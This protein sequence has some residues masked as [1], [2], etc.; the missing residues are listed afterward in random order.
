MGLEREF[1]LEVLEPIRSRG[2][3]D[4]T[5]KMLRAVGVHVQEQV[6]P[7]GLRLIVPARSVI[8]PAA[9]LVCEGDWSTAAAL[10]AVGAALPLG[11]PI[12]ELKGLSPTS[13]Q[14]DRVF[15]DWLGA[16]GARVEWM[17]SSLTVFP[18]R[19]SLRG[20]RVS[21][22]RSPDLVPVF[23]ALAAI[24]E[25]RSEVHSAPQLRHK[26]SDRIALGVRLANLLGAQAHETVDGF[27]VDSSAG[28]ELPRSGGWSTDHDHRQVMAAYV[29]FAGGARFTIDDVSVVTKSAP[30]F[31]EVMRCLG[32]SSQAARFLFLGHRGAG[33]TSFARRL[34]ESSAGRLEVCD[35]DQEIERRYERSI[36]DIFASDGE[37][38]FRE[39]ERQELEFWLRQPVSEHGRVI[40]AGAGIELDQLEPEPGMRGFRFW[41]RAGYEAVWVSR[42]T[43]LQ[44]RVFLDRPRLHPELSAI[45]EYRLRAQAR[46][47]RYQRWSSRQIILR[48]GADRGNRAS[49]AERTVIFGLPDFSGASITIPQ[50]VLSDF[51]RL[52]AWVSLRRHWSFSFF[53]VRE[54]Y[55]PSELSAPV[56]EALFQ[57]LSTLGAK[58]LIFS[59]RVPRPGAGQLVLGA[60]VR[61]AGGRIDWAQELGDSNTISDAHEGDIQSIH[62]ELPPQRGP[63]EGI[64]KWSPEI[65]DWKGL[66]EGHQWWAQDPKHRVFLPRSPQGIWRHYRLWSAR[67]LRPALFF[68]REGVGSALDQPT[69]V[70]WLEN[71]GAPQEFGAVLGDPVLH[72]RSPERHGPHF[73]GFP[74]SREEFGDALEFLRDQGLN[75]A[76]VT[77]PLKEDCFQWVR[78]LGHTSKQPVMIS[79]RANRLAS[80]NTLFWCADESGRSVLQADNTDLPG[81]ES[82][83]ASLG[84]GDG[85]QVALW[86]GGGTLAMVRALLPS[87]RAYSARTG[88]VKPGGEASARSHE[89]PRVVIW[90]VGRSIFSGLFPP[91]SWRPELVIDLNYAEDSP[92]RDY[93]A[94]LLGSARYL[95]GLAFFEAQAARQFRSVKPMTH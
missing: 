16:M 53:E 71:R 68:L 24:A 91:Q 82:V 25:G 31:L 59:R 51:K 80:V 37:A 65:Q 60:H 15:I 8:S 45:E 39:L 95:S 84:L 13:L 43:D 49:L 6:I 22:E 10:M 62:G 40:V 36:S 54:D 93:A 90:G 33:K 64:L 38:R 67:R 61:E 73:F 63:H 1:S 89:S 17:G 41:E 11:A 77:S 50:S 29:A 34:R 35:L 52:A 94:R 92:G 81:F 18:S 46:D 58:R 42:E 21:G 86:G 9:V 85:S 47:Q 26:E 55:L 27:V 20:I 76:A 3:L 12:L 78:Q 74:V 66:R 32:I 2:Y 75:R 4:L 19:Q 14:P 48:E 57:V 87:V 7:E 72:S 28:R 70:E 5:L 79:D 83:I 56:G 23:A 69:L 88:M 44:G 30:E